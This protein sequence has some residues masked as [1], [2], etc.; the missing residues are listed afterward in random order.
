MNVLLKWAG[1]FLVLFGIVSC[2]YMPWFW[3]SYTHPTYGFSLT[4]PR[5]W[6]L[7]EGSSFGTTLTLVPPEDDRLFLTNA[8]LV[9]EANANKLTLDKLTEKSKIQLSQLLNQYEVLAQ[10]PTSL[11]NLKANEIRARYQATEG[12]RLIRTWIAVSDS[13]V[14]VF[15]FTCRIQNESN[16]LKLLPHMIQSFNF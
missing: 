16:Y 10:A 3:K 8:N 11:G 5:S 12:E 7:K 1:P 4:Y 15:T 9:V 2:H 13:F 6:T 14:Y